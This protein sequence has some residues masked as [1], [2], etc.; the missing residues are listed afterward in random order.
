MPGC[1]GLTKADAFRVIGP[2]MITWFEEN[3][4][5]YNEAAQR[6][7][8]IVYYAYPLETEPDPGPDPGLDPG[9]DPVDCSTCDAELSALKTKIQNIKDQL[10]S[11]INGIGD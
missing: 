1:F 11:I 9:P 7:L 2:M 8:E 10:Q 6:D 3:R 4:P 5:Q